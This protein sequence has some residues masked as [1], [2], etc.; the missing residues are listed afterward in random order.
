[1]HTELSAPL[2]LL[3]LKGRPRDIWIQY[4]CGI[5]VEMHKIQFPEFEGVSK[6]KPG[7][8]SK[9]SHNM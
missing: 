8:V 1:M 4:R 6:E 5:F 3:L 2:K 7:F 9:T